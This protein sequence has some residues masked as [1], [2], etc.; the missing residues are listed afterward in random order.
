MKAQTG[1][2]RGTLLDAVTGQPLPYANMVLLRAQDS[3]F[4]AGAQTSETGAFALEQLAWG[5]YSLRA[6]VVGYRTGRRI[7]RLSAAAPTL[8]L[9]TLR[10][11]AT[12]VQ[13]QDVVATAERPVLSGNLDKKVIDVSKYLT[14]TGGTAL[15]VLQNVP[16][17]SV[18]Q[19]GAVSL[20]GS[21]GVTVFIDD[22]RPATGQRHPERG[23]HY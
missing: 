7:S 9:G 4:V 13:L 12:T 22:A 20:R 14:V 18:D 6:P 8:A 21:S 11:R 15:D 23:G 1:A 2:V 5:S 10:L 19:N 16:S 3:S 17:V